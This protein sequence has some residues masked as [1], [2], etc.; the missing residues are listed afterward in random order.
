MIT[1]SI[2]GGTGSGLGSLLMSRM[3]AD[4]GSKKSQIGLTVFPSANYSNTIV[5]PYNAALSI[6]GLLNYQDLT[7]PL[8]NESLYNISARQLGS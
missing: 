7:I 3:D 1:N 6:S 5:E 2:S 4:Y 8:N